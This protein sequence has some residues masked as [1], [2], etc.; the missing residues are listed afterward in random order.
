MGVVNTAVDFVLYVLLWMLGVAPM[1]ANLAST[2]A[3][4]VVSFVGNR[5]WVFRSGGRARDELVRFL[6]I[7]GTGIWLIQPAVILGLGKVEWFAASALGAA[8]AKFVAIAVAAV[9]NYLLY[10]RWVFR[11]A[12]DDKGV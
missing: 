3:G 8:A 6:L 5:R 10:S 9:W 1:V 12:S 7:A 4:L 11:H 2:S